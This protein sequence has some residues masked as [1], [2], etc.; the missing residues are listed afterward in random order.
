MN[1][2]ISL[3]AAS[4][5]EIAAVREKRGGCRRNVGETSECA[6]ATR[7]IVANSWSVPSV[8]QY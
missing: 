2:F 1:W 3:E 4:A 6:A 7:Q 8:D 5:V